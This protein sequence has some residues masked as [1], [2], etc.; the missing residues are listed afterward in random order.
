MRRRRR[1]LHAAELAL[2][3]LA[4]SAMDGNGVAG[5]ASGHPVFLCRRCLTPN[6]Q[7]PTP[8]AIP[9]PNFQQKLGSPTANLLGSWRLG[10][11]WELGV[12]R[13]ELTTAGSRTA[14]RGRG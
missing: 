8:K 7:R 3:V 1:S 5:H 12:G 14:P 10:M 13:W 6:S 11:P 4:R 2:H 9:T